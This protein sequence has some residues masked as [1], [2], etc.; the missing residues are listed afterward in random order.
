MYF[1]ICAFSGV[2][3]RHT[4]FV[5]LLCLPPGDG[6]LC[7]QAEAE[8][9]QIKRNKEQVFKTSPGEKLDFAFMF[10]NSNSR[11][12]DPAPHGI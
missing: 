4:R 12:R 3:G 9:G 1:C 11:L 7:P 2:L 8:D 10:I 6:L 5:W